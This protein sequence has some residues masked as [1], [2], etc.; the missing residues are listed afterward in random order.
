MQR[1]D[2]S[3]QQMRRK[4]I[5]EA[6]PSSDKML[7]APKPPPKNGSCQQSAHWS[8]SRPCAS[9]AQYFTTGNGQVITHNS[10][11]SLNCY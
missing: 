2:K 11:A 4:V 10:C 3:P 1:K 7:H 5:R 9:A 8:H 6:R